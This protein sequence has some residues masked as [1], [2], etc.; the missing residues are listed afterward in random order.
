MN[1]MSALVF[2]SPLLC[3]MVSRNTARRNSP[4]SRRRH[5]VIAALEFAEEAAAHF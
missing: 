4:C 2:S 3:A 5:F 1:L